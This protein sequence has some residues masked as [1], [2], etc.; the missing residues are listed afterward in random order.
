MTVNLQCSIITS[1]KSLIMLRQPHYVFLTLII[2]MSSVAL[3]ATDIYLPALPEMAVY[4]NCSQTEIQASFT[5]FLLG[6]GCCQLISGVLADW[7]GRRKVLLLGMS[8]F[9]FASIGCAL[10][11]SL[12]EFIIFRLLQAVGCV[13]SVVSRSIVADRYSRPE[14]VKIFSTVFPIVGMSAAVAPLVGGYLTSFFNWR[15]PFI[16]IAG[17]GILVFLLVV[18]QL[19][20]AP[21][22]REEKNEKR[23][24]PIGRMRGYIDV[25]RNIEFVGYTLVICAGFC[26]FRSYTVESPFVFN[27]QGYVTEEIGHLYIT[28]SV[29]Y[30]VGNLMAKKLVNSMRVEAVLKIGFAMLV[31]GGISL[32]VCAYLFDDNAYAVTLPMAIVTLGNGFLFPIGSAAAMTSVPSTVSGTASGLLGALQVI[33]A[34]ACINCVGN[35]CQGR[36]LH[37][38]LFIGA[39]ILLGFCIYLCL[40]VYRPKSDVSI[41]EQE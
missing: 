8:I 29:A 6:L 35:I 10:S 18:F 32:I 27:K 5:V 33:F 9:T 15:A 36:A 3:L 4:F 11:T 34:A 41:M 20:D 17:F 13:G 30:I 37:M 31:L 16:F 23:A 28:L 1:Q 7:L 12:T 19:R 39:I 40:I 14:A 2:F 25:L 26:V 22:S 38:S 21:P 24:K